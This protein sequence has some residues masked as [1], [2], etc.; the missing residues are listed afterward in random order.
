MSAHAYAAFGLTVRSNRPLAGLHPTDDASAASSVEVVFADPPNGAHE[1]PGVPP[2][3][4]TGFER[5]WHLDG[6]QRLLHYVDP[7]VGEAWSMLVSHG[8]I[9]VRYGAATDPLQMAPVVETA[10]LSTALHLAGTPQ[11]HGAAL[12]VDDE[13]ILVVGPSGAGKS[14]T[15]A[16]FVARGHALLSDDVAAIADAPGGF[17]VHPGPARLRVLPVTARAVGWEAER[18]PRVFD[19]DMMGDKRAVALSVSEGSYCADARPL[20]AV[21]VLAPR[22]EADRPE[23][24][25]VSPRDRLSLVLRDTYRAEALDAGRRARLLPVQARFA[26]TVPMRRLAAPDAHE[27]LRSVL[28]A[29]VADV[30]ATRAAPGTSRSACAPRRERPRRP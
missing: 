8:R 22:I 2:V 16:A 21:Y 12:V 6:D 23:L 10:G 4:Q 9:D 3:A 17:A 29:I 27:A 18:L 26:G 11:L 25:D 24:S 19:A 30:R 14:T 5:V 28:D 13:A 1:P 7:A 20:A 15:A